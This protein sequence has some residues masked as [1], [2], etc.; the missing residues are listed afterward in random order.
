MK[1]KK[2]SIYV[3]EYTLYDNPFLPPN[4]VKQIELAYQGT[5][6]FD[7]YVLGKWVNAEGLI[8]RPF[9]D[10]PNKYYITKEEAKNMDIKYINIG[11]DFGG[12]LSNHA[13]VCTGITRD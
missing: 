7:R 5:V 6:F 1:A 4:T 13:F 10:N 9:A 8:Y 11:H 3:Q 2:A 12:N